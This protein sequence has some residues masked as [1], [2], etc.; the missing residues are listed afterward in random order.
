MLSTANLSELQ[1]QRARILES[2]RD[3]KLI[4]LT[5][6]WFELLCYE[7]R[8]AA[9]IT[10]ADFF[11]FFLINYTRLSLTR[12]LTRLTRIYQVA[13]H[14]LFFHWTFPRSIWYVLSGIYTYKKGEGCR[15]TTAMHNTN[16]CFLLLNG[17][18]RPLAEDAACVQWS[19]FLWDLIIPQICTAR[20]T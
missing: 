13:S 10:N 9:M 12:I 18:G 15:Q 19:H 5:K 8:V 7:F 17:H 3:I 14:L 20:F 16:R 11:E 4:H 2:L 1:E 6:L